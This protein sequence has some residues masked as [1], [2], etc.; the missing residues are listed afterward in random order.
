MGG[1]GQRVVVVI[2]TFRVDLGLGPAVDPEGVVGSEVDQR[3]R[4][5][6]GS[7]LP[8]R[9]RGE[10]D[11]ADEVVVV[12]GRGRVDSEPVELGRGFDAG[13]LDDDGVA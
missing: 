2:L 4:D 5:V 10:E 7:G 11:V 8:A 12:G 9:G 3:D 1:S 13:P 6:P